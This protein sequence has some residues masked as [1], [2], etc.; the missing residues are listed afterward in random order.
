M[1]ID[2][3]GRLLLIIPPSMSFLGSLFI[4]FSLK[5]STSDHSLQTVDEK[6]EAK[7][8]A[9]I[10]SHRPWLGIAGLVLISVGFA[11]QS[12]FTMCI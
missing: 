12:L 6:G 7:S 3:C 11:L 8:V 2:A 1:N 9:T 4:I 5:L 10:Q